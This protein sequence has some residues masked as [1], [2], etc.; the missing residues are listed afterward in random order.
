MSGYRSSRCGKRDDPLHV[1]RLDAIF[2]FEDSP[3]SDERTLRVGGDIDLLPTQLGGLFDATI[4]A[5]EDGLVAEGA[6]WKC[7][8]QRLVAQASVLRVLVTRP[9]H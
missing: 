9:S 6:E 8:D 2:V 4:A 1:A 7:G 3:N 5:H